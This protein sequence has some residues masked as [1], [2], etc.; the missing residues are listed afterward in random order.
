MIIGKKVLAIIP[1]RKSSEE[2]KNKNIR[3]FNKKPLIFWTLKAAE[4]SKLIDEVVV[5]SNSNKILNYSKK[6]KK[7]T[8][9]KRPEYLSTKKSE[10][11]DTIFFEMKKFV[12]CEII[13]LLQPTSPLRRSG[14]IDKSLQEMI[15]NKRES[16][17]SYT[18]IKYNPYNFYFIKKNKINFLINKKKKIKSTNRQSFKKVFYPSGDIY[19]STSNRLK[20]KKNFIDLK[21]Y[22]Y[23]VSTKRASDIDNIWDFKTAEFKLK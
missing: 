14:D 7:F 17:V 10:I 4:K 21:T 9:S 1:A 23:I 15:S 6:F 12:N 20:K 3:K 5:S 2:L 13:I 18:E 11:I 19:I 16:C 22:P 8:L